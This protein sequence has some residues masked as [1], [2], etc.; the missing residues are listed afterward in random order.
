VDRDENDNVDVSDLDKNVIGGDGTSTEQTMAR[1]PFP[2][3]E[4]SSLARSGKGTIEGSI[5]L[6]DAYGTKI[7]GAKTRLYLNPV[8]S[9]STQWYKESYI[10]GN[11]MSE[12]DSRLF[13]YLR[14]TASDSNG[15]FAFYGV[16]SGSYYLIGTV[17]CASEC[18]YDT[19]K[20]IRVAT[21]VKVVGNQIVHKDLYRQVSQ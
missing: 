12:P 21:K 10:K 11:K 2:E 20:N 4:Y 16:P 5:Y 7:P 9:Y 17:T 13:N 14:F 15:H 6:Q 8:T 3:G 1:I 19:P 18:G